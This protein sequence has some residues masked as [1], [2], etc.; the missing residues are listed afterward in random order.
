MRGR[1]RRGWV[2]LVLPILGALPTA[3]AQAGLPDGRG[4][5]L[6]SPSAKQGN[7]VIAESSRTRAAAREAPGLPMAAAFASL[8]GFADVRGMGVSTEYLAQRTA[9]PGTS[10]W[11][12]HAITPPQQPLSILAAA[13]GL[14][15]LYEGDMTPDLRRGVFRAWSPL[16]A[17]VNAQDVP[18]LYLREDLR[19]AGAGSYRLLTDAAAPPA[20]GSGAVRPYLAGAS[21][22]LEHVIFESQLALTPDAAPGSTMLYKADHGVVRLLTAGPGCP[23]TTSA[24]TPCSIAGAGASTRRLTSRALSADGSRVAFAWPVDP[25]SGSINRSAAAPSG[26]YQLDDGGT[27]DPADD[28]TLQVDASEKAPPDPP[29]AARF[30]TASTDGERVF[31]TSGTQLTDT[32]GAGLY[33]WRRTPDAGGR[34]LT[35]IGG[36]S[37][38]TAVGASDDGRRVYLLAVGQLIAGGP[39][40]G[41]DGLYLWQDDGTPGGSLSFVGAVAFADAAAFN[42][43][44]NPWNLG[45][46]L[47]RVT[48]DGGT[49]A[50]EVSDGSGLGPRADHGS[51]SGRN[52]NLRANGRCSEVYVYRAAGSGPL[53]PDLACASCDPGGAPASAN[54]FV[55]ARDGAGAAQVTAHLGR[56]LSDDGRRVFFSTAQALVREDVNGRVDAY[57]YDVPSRTVHLISSGLDAA[58][59]WFLDASASGDD[60]FFTTRAQLVGWD[61]DA[62]YDLYDAR[63]GG[64]LPE[65]AAAG[66]AC[67]G[68]ACRGAAHAAPAAPALA[69][70]LFAGAGGRSRVLPRRVAKRC[71]RGRVA[72]RVHGKRRCVKAKKVHRRGRR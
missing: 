50:F 12:T 49:L 44:A 29:Q 71:R 65:P 27:A 15:P 23:G 63:V 61:V 70:A 17:A 52:P 31:F 66:A 9:E 30:E 25:D 38:T 35:L 10:G 51:C 6:V 68:D 47:A 36:D 18:N 20:L 2:L 64:G 55:N 19:T 42:N 43:S 4:W 67:D 53:A 54:A 60:V 28:A 40:V 69:S 46:D 57:E 45:P 34:H 22:D 13:N 39:P 32:P 48:P 14:D 1:V 59:A 56:A 21:A 5:E 72:R 24:A 8:G 3:A 11:T 62:S 37:T 16:T 41:Q 26:L 33:L 7:D 58:D